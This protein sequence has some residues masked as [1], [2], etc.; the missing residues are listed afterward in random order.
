MA[1]RERM[2]RTLTISDELYGQLEAEARRRG[3][4]SVEQ[5]LEQWQVVKAGVPSR[6]EVV[7]EIDDLRNSLL[8]RYGEMPDSAE[9]LHRDRAR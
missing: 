7:R 4:P 8:A 5:L 3:L 9:L 6:S 1:K 2:S